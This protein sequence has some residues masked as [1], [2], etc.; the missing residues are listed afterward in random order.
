MGVD[1]SFEGKTIEI[2]VTAFF[3]HNNSSVA[4]VILT[5]KMRFSMASLII[6]V[7]DRKNASWSVIK[8]GL[9]FS[10]NPTR[11][12]KWTLMHTYITS[13]NSCAKNTKISEKPNN[14]FDFLW[15]FIIC[16]ACLGSTK[17]EC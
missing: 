17:M 7:R 3:N 5:S 15:K 1:Y 4:T 14:H 8:A 11:K 9:Y 16:H 2:W 13:Q 12:I 10:L 6:L